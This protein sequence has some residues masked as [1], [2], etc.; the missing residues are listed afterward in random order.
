MT[1]TLAGAGALV[2]LTTAAAGGRVYPLPQ[3]VNARAARAR[4]V[5]TFL[6]WFLVCVPGWIPVSIPLLIPC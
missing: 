5:A 6:V 4:P 2:G 3:P 1:A